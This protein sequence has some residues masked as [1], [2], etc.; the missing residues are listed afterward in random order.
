[1]CHKEIISMTQFRTSLQKNNPGVVYADAL[2]FFQTY[3]FC[4]DYQF[5][6]EKAVENKKLPFSLIPDFVTAYQFAVADTGFIAL[7]EALETFEWN[8][9]L[10][11]CAEKIGAEKF[12]IKTHGSPRY[13]F[14][15]IINSNE[16][17]KIVE[18]CYAS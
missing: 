8:K 2:W 17:D 7:A 13:I 10:K 15:N 9:L 3:D 11:L 6:L 4:A 5:F 1:M 12:D 18:N 14:R 16:F